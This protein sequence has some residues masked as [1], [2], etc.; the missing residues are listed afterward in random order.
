MLKGALFPSF[1]LRRGA[2]GRGG[3][4]TFHK[5]LKR[6]EGSESIIDKLHVMKYESFLAA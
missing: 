6:Q 1:G 4:V 2:V 5:R 3:S